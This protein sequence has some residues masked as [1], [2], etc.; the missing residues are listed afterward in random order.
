MGEKNQF[1]T[2][3]SPL[4]FACKLCQSG[5]TSVVDGN[6]KTLGCTE[7]TAGKY[8]SEGDPECTDCPAGFY[9]GPASANID[10]C[11]MCPIAEYSA[12]GTAEGNCLSCESGK[13]GNLPGQDECNSCESGQCVA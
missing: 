2:S 10:A 12:A 1:F 4:P 9:S 13:Y 11:E 5:K 6:G 3:V 8:S 7:C